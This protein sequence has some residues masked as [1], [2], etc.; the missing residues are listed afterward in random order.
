MNGKTILLVEDDFLNRRLTKKILQED[1][2]HILEAKNA[3]EAMEILTKCSVSL[4]ILDINLGEEEM[5]GIN[6]GRH[7]KDQFHIPFIY[8]TAYDNAKVISEA[9]PTSPYSYLTKPFKNSDLITS[10]KIALI[11]SSELEKAEPKILIKHEN[12]TIELP[13]TE[14]NYIESEKNYLLFFTDTK[15]YKHRS[16][17]KLIMD[18]LPESLFVQTHRAFVVNKNKIKKFTQNS[19]VLQNVV[20]PVSKNYVFNLSIDL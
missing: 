6:L 15:T 13:I 11:K 2:F 1:G 5:N 12:Y 10:V 8:L 18:E 7:I 19:V 3:K 16:T 9:L 17:I 14:I 4:A 20:I